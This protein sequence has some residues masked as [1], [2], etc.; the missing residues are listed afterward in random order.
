MQFNAAQRLRLKKQ[1][2]KTFLQ[3]TG[4]QTSWE[5]DFQESSLPPPCQT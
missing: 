4:K 2:D 3:F 1:L 5:A